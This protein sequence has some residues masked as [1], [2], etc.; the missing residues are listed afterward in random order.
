MDK[1]TTIINLRKLHRLLAKRSRLASKIA[2]GLER[3]S[4]NHY[5]IIDKYFDHFFFKSIRSSDLPSFDIIKTLADIRKP[6]N[7]VS[8]SETATTERKTANL[9]PFQTFLWYAAII[10]ILTI[11][12]LPQMFGWGVYFLLVIILAAAISVL[13][14][15]KAAEQKRQ[16][17]E[18]E[19]KALEKAQEPVQPETIPDAL[20]EYDEDARQ[21]II[22]ALNS[23]ES[24]V[25]RETQKLADQKAILPAAFAEWL[26]VYKDDEAKYNEWQQKQKA[27][28]EEQKA[29]LNKLDEEI[30][31]IDFIRPKY[32]Y[33]ITDIVD[34]LESGR[35]DDYKEALNLAIEVDERRKHNA[36]MEEIEQKKVRAAEQQAEEE[37]RHNEEM[38][39][40]AQEAAFRAEQMQA[41]HNRAMERAAENQAKAIRQAADDAAKAR[42]EADRA[43]QRADSDARTRAWEQCRVC[44]KFS[45]CRNPGNPGCGAF[46]PR[47]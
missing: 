29:F 43:A 23:Y 33:L 38:E 32:Y 24:D 41:E 34:L 12:V 37:R 31:T 47:H 8:K 25:R 20:A 16:A 15:K 22:D 18:A 39:W 17:E 2:E 28:R 19:R 44:A 45:G 1:Q 11:G 6:N 3:P 46:V 9:S 7:T 13:S 5:Q 14:N 30:A 36:R 4:S 26:E 40:Q 42:K 21:K 10:A 27:W 35:A